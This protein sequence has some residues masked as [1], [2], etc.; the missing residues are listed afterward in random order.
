M[1]TS[2][3]GKSN[4]IKVFSAEELEKATNNYDPNLILHEDWGYAFYRGT[5]AHGGRTIFVKKFIY[6]LDD[7]HQAR[8]VLEGT[9]NEVAIASQLNH[10]NVLKLLGCCLETQIPIQVYEFASNGNLYH[11]VC[12]IEGED[13][14][15]PT[16]PRHQISWKSRL[17]I[18][19]EIAYAI[20]YLH[21]STSKPIVHRDVKSSN[22]F[23][24][25]H[26]VAKLSDFTHSV[27]I[28]LGET[29][30]K[31]DVQGTFGFIA[32]EYCRLGLVTEKTDV[33]SFGMLLLEL[34][35]GKPPLNF[36]CSVEDFDLMFWEY[37]RSSVQN[38]PLSEIVDPAILEEIR[39]IEQQ[40]QA[41]VELSLRCIRGTAEERPT[42]MEAAKELRRIQ[43]SA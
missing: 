13:N 36:H 5:T 42:I 25:E 29:H 3:I 43:R 7:E 38:Y 33:F 26:F 8:K 24:D 32:P 11:S 27:P 16:R 37:V 4:P 22:I 9:V 34:L 30:V 6:R 2:C 21:K 41:F 12:R 28:P 10:K 20:T 39:G 35:M 19:T 31:D 18:A 23:L 40:V 17:R 14:E 1:I 15:D